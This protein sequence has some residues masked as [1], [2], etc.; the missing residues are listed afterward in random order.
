V[1]VF[2]VNP[3][4]SVC[5]CPAENIIATYV[6]IFV[7]ADNFVN[8][9]W[10]KNYCNLSTHIRITSIHIKVTVILNDYHSHNVKTHT[11]RLAKDKPEFQ[12]SPSK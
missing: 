11:E 3:S 6:P 10:R 8:V 7:N 4:H 9:L 1:C 2:Y 5:E 12:I